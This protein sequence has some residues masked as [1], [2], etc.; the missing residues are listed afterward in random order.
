M[1]LSKYTVK[2]KDD[3]VK[4]LNQCIKIVQ[5]GDVC[6]HNNITDTLEMEF[7]VRRKGISKTIN[8]G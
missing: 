3:L 7:A 2:E 5:S 8:N 6:Y 4:F 1:E